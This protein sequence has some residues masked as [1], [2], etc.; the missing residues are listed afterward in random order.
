MNV[1]YVAGPFAG[2]PWWRL[3]QLH[4]FVQHGCAAL[5]SQYAPAKSLSFE[6]LA[7]L[8]IYA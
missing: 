6:V 4:E 2:N 8:W 7:Y 5:E 3:D 1:G